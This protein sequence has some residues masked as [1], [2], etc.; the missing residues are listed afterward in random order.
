M[1][2]K[3]IFK[4]LLPNIPDSSSCPFGREASRSCFLAGDERVN[5]QPVIAA[6][7]MIFTRFHNLVAEQLSAGNPHMPDDMVF[8]EARKI[9]IAV[10]QIIIYQEFLP[11]LLGP[12]VLDS[13]LYRDAGL[14]L[15]D[16]GHFDQYEPEADPHV[17]NEFATA[18]FR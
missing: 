5:Q 8:H 12:S 18:G 6:V 15:N 7:H 17:L 1:Q 2:N 3:D 9:V 13:E 11:G 4:Q 16:L 14:Q 10:Y